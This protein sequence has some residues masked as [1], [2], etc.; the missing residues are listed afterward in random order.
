MFLS[1]SLLSKQKSISPTTTLYSSFQNY[2]R[3][4]EIPTQ[5]CCCLQVILARKNYYGISRS[6][7]NLTKSLIIKCIWQLDKEL[8]TIQITKMLKISNSV[9]SF[10]SFK[11]N[12]ENLTMI[13][14]GVKSGG[15]ES[16]TH[17]DYCTRQITLDNLLIVLGWIHKAVLS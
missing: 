12:W 1:C 2:T 3:K 8:S 7:D 17:H 16:L 14:R 9:P 11:I 5:L 10:Q 13:R 15:L 4:T 6:G